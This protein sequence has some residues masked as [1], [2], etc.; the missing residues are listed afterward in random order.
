MQSN[1]E[2]KTTSIKGVSKL[3][4]YGKKLASGLGAVSEGFYLVYRHGLYKDINNPQNT[5]YVQY[6]CRRLCKVFNIDV[7]VHGDIPRKP[8]LWVSNHISWLDV[9][10]LGSGARVFFLAK[11]EIEKW[12]VF[13]KLAK[14][15]G[16]LFIQ[17]GSGDSIKIREQITAFLKQDIPV[18]FFPEATTTDG[19][20]VKKVH[21]RILGAAIEAQRDVQ[22]CLIC[23]VNQQGGLDQVSPFIGN[24]SF[25]EHVKK[26][27]EMPQVTAHL[28][29][30]PAICT[31]GHTVESLTALVQQ[32]MVQG[33]ADLHHK[34]LKSQ[35]NIEQA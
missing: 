8:A 7:H 34:V 27:L 12:P 15:G 2:I 18:L 4:L 30:L 19:S 3:F 21:G 28:V 14:S 16:T 35:L 25:A 6:F 1:T 10:V 11:A 32:K 22:I 13:G 9:A 29:A 17:R 23:Y 31:T 24:I 26:V 20:K 5:R 33:L